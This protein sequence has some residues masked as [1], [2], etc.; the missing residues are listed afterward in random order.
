M[1]D[2]SIK[3]LADAQAV[4]R[5]G[6]AY[7]AIQQQDGVVCAAGQRHAFFGNAD[8]V[9]TEMFREGIGLSLPSGVP[10]EKLKY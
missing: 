4:C 7:I 10:G 6:A 2:V 3:C 5:I 1:A 9:A 8:H